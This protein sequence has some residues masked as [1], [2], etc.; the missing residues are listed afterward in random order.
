MS[1][2][3]SYRRKIDYILDKLR[4]L[5]SSFDNEFMV[6][7]LLYRLHTSIEAAMD[8]I[9]MLVKDLGKNVMDDYSNIETL[10][11]LGIIDEKLADKLKQLNGLRNI[12]VHR[13]NKVDENIII[14]SL[15]DI[16][17][18][19]FKFVEIVENVLREIYK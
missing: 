8:I 2:I 9:A 17:G 16:V 3:D 1:R 18:T 4:E 11:G 10:N 13:Y 5:P 12:I 15:E 6:D 14:E 7:A 19:L